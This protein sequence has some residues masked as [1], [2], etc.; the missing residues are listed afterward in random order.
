MVGRPNTHKP[1]FEVKSEGRGRGGGGGGGRSG[2]RGRG[3]SRESPDLSEC[4]ESEDDFWHFMEDLM[5]Q[6][7][8][9]PGSY[10]SKGQGGPG[11]AGAGK[12]KPSKK[13]SKKAKRN[14][15]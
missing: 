3:R 1:S 8:A 2:G 10:G 14:G 9:P 7:G 6:G 4:F 5:K 15:W 12:P 13:Q 11:R